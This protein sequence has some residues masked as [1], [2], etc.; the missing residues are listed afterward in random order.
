MLHKKHAK[1]FIKTITAKILVKLAFA[2]GI[3]TP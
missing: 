1:R 2:D 3:Y